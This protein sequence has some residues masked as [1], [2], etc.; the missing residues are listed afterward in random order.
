M[1]LITRQQEIKDFL[2]DIS[3]RKIMSKDKVMYWLVFMSKDEVMYW[4][5]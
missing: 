3:L 5:V 4:L 2:K 1:H